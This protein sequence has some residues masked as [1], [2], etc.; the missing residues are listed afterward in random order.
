MICRRSRN[1]ILDKSGVVTSKHAYLDETTTGGIAACVCVLGE[2]SASVVDSDG[3][4]WI[5]PMEA[6]VPVSSAAFV[7]VNTL[8]EGVASLGVTT[9]DDPSAA[10]NGSTEPTASA[11]FAAS[12]ALLSIS[13]IRRWTM[14]GI[15]FTYVPISRWLERISF[16]AQLSTQSS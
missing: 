8:G 15:S 2:T 12:A 9:V 14:A 1:F 4:D 13:S 11:A 5:V 7:G 10:F 6:T 16:P 3:A